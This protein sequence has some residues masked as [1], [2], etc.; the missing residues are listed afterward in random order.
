MPRKLPGRC[1][2]PRI[3]ADVSRI[4]FHECTLL[5]IV[6]MQTTFYIVANL[7]SRNIFVISYWISYPQ[8]SL[9]VSNSVSANTKANRKL[10]LDT[11]T[12]DHIITE[13]TM[14][15]LGNSSPAGSKERAGG[16]WGVEI[17][18]CEITDLA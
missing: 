14:V 2:N 8:G 10:S 1:W 13:G 18:G 12:T 7:W 11:Y 3:W 16:A 9:I 4:Y 15:F 6:M 17:C 5:K